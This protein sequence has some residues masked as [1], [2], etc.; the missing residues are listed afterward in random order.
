LTAATTHQEDLIVYR[1]FIFDKHA[2]AIGTPE[3]RTASTVEIVLLCLLMFSLPQFEA[4]GHIFSGLFMIAYL[5]QSARTH[6]FG[7]HTP[8]EW[9]VWILLA[10]ALLAP[11]TSEYSSQVTIW[12]ARGWLIIGATAIVAGRLSYTDQQFQYI[13][14]A[15]IIGGIVGVA[16]G[17]WI[18]TNNHNEYPELRSVGH[19][20]Q[21]AL[22]LLNVIAVGL[23][24]LISDSRWLKLLGVFGIVAAFLFLIPSRSLVSVAVA[25]VL[26]SIGTSIL[27]STYLNRKAI[28]VST[29]V[30][31]LGFLM[32]LTTPYAD[33]FRHELLARTQAGSFGQ[34]DSVFS[35]RDRIFLTAIEVYDR[36]P[37]FGSGIRTFNLATSPEVVRAELTEEGRDFDAEASRFVFYPYHGHNLWTTTL[38]ERGLVGVAA[39]TAYLII[40][41]KLFIRPALSGSSLPKNQRVP[42]VLGFLIVSYFTLAG[43]GQTTT[44]VEHGQAGMMLLSIAW[45]A[46]R[47]AATSKL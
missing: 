19:V 25:C 28:L 18:W 3:R 10:V 31:I 16:E 12:W 23:A 22:Y 36:N 15:V 20:N 40:I 11:M 27:I 39:V 44:Y 24:A 6:N 34:E 32:L 17:L 5:V 46:Y 1:N 2:G 13:L 38:I 45:T 33:G 30:V 42:A 35:G 14:A 21:S 47:S 26:M 7:R 4:P 29:A 8:F 41:L 9:P 43:L 37:I